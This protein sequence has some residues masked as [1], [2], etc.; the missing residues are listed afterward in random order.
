MPFVKRQQYNKSPEIIAF[1]NGNYFTK[2]ITLEN[3]NVPLDDND[4]R[5]I[6]AGTIISEIEGTYRFLPRVK[7]T[8]NVATDA[9]ELNVS[10]PF[11]LKAGDDLYVVLPYEIVTVGTAASTDDV[12]TVTIN[13]DI[14]VTAKA[15][16]DEDS[17]KAATANF[18]ASKINNN[19]QASHHVTAFSDGVDKVWVMANN[20]FSRPSIAVDN[21]GTGTLSVGDANVYLNTTSI[22]T[23]SSIDRVNEKVIIESQSGLSN[24]IPSGVAI[25]VRDAKVLGL[26]CHDYDMTDKYVQN[27]GLLTKSNGV[28]KN[29]LPYLD[30]DV[31]Y[32]LSEIVFGEKF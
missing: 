19:F 10:N 30:T 1:N 27:F 31:E 26:I 23:V 3:K 25:G 21:A 32:Q 13:G 5:T 16:A 12:M 15:T 22:G 6:P 11:S 7:T 18:L 28:F 14:V 2:S 8:Q 29:R 4:S 17:D 20:I 9:T 24:I